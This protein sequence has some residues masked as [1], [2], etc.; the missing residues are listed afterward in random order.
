MAARSTV[1][2]MTRSLLQP[3]AVLTTLVVVLA[4]VPS[5]AENPSPHYGSDP[6]L[7]ASPDG[8][9]DSRGDGSG[10]EREEERQEEKQEEDGDGKA[11]LLAS[12][13]APSTLQV[14]SCGGIDCRDEFVVS[15]LS[16]AGFEIRGPP[17]R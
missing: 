4:G 5:W 7:H 14:R 15:H 11:R 10:E 2:I 8:S 6:C 17:T 3:F 9:R 12:S 16:A 13:D 1:I